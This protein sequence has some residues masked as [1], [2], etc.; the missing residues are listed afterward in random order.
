MNRED[1]QC[2]VTSGLCVRRYGTARCHDTSHVEVSIETSSMTIHT[3]PDESDET[4]T[5]VESDLI[6][7]KYA[8]S[9]FSVKQNV[10]FLIQLIDETSKLPA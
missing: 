1:A 8:S 7:H 6:I 2:Y 3:R 4:Q 5:P 10:F 9:D